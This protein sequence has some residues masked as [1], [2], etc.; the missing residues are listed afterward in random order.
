MRLGYTGTQYG[1]SRS[2]LRE[3]IAYIELHKPTEAHHG[4]CIGG[5][6][7]FHKIC[8]ERGIPIVGHPPTNQK[9]MMVVRREEF[10]KMW[11]PKPYLDRNCDIVLCSTHMI[12]GPLS[13]I[14]MARGSGTWHAIRYARSNKVPLTLLER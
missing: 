3:L 4:L 2:Q 6:E 7:Q 12:A 5:D 14:E 11:A 13:M 1:M 9:K 8:H 10:H